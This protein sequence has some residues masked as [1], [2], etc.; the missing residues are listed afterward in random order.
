MTSSGTRTFNPPNSSLVLAAYERIGI[1]SPSFRQEHMFSAKNE[2][3]FL[4]SE[5][6]NL[7]P[8][9][10]EITLTSTSLTSGT[11]TYT[12]DSKIVMVLDAY[13]STSFGTTSQTDIYLNPLSRTEYA[14]IAQKQTAGQPT[15]YWFDR[16]I[17]PTLTLWPV[18]NSST[19]WE[20][21]YYSCNTI[22]DANLA[23]GETLDVPYRWLDAVVAGLSH[24]LSRI[25][26][27]Q[28]E[29]IRE[30]DAEKAWSRAAAQD[31]ENVGFKISPSLGGY[32][33]R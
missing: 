20:L 24:R 18:P 30:K 25:Y 1:R 22:Q 21:S 7:Q 33:R 2:L 4:L 28:L 8:N 12:L 32:Y 19:T 27:P 14:V 6:S 3:N 13:I 9:L 23:G 11:A 17:V 26:A 16:Q 10:W 5:M 29:A 15:Q 31:T